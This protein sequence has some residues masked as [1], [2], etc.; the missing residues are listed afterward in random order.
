MV[1]YKEAERTT[2]Y[3]GFERKGDVIWNGPLPSLNKT[4]GEFL[5]ISRM[6]RKAAIPSDSLRFEPYYEI[7]AYA[8]KL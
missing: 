7:G 6:S 5:R 4:Q 8:V 3:L 2:V 1:S